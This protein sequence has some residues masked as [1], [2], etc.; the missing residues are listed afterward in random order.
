MQFL[1]RAFVADTKYI[2]YWLEILLEVQLAAGK[3]NKP[4][5]ESSSIIFPQN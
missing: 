2:S 5:A 4:L 1:I 3:C